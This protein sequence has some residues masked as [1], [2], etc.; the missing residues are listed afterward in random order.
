MPSFITWMVNAVK[1]VVATITGFF[2]QIFNFFRNKPVIYT[3]S[4]DDN[5]NRGNKNPIEYSYS[6]SSDDIDESIT[7]AA[8][9]R[10]YVSDII[11]SLNSDKEC[12][13]FMVDLHRVDKMRFEPTYISQVYDLAKYSIGRKDLVDDTLIS[14]NLTMERMRPTLD[15][16]SQTMPHDI[17][18]ML[19]E[20]YPNRH[21]LSSN[22]GSELKISGNCISLRYDL[23]VYVTKDRE[24]TAEN[25]DAKNQQ[26]G[27]LNI[28]TTAT[29]D[30]SKLQIENDNI[31]LVP[32]SNAI[33]HATTMTVPENNLYLDFT[34]IDRKMHEEKHPTYSTLIKK[35]IM[36]FFKHNEPRSNTGSKQS[37]GTS[38]KNKM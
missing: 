6:V 35:K 21:F 34:R 11:D 37:V 33:I 16:F 38:L 12:N 1:R 31:T 9:P 23:N 22:I 14:F 24:I 3:I 5:I 25:I 2:A 32:N 29:L 4:S 26:E 36:T 18:S 27:Q 20:L 8:S 13:Q 15:F 19:H 30:L 10:K 7:D 28:S 17:L